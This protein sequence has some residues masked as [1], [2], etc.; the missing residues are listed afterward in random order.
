MWSL[1][2]TQEVDF[3]IGSSKDFLVVL[4]SLRVLA[5]K[6]GW[7]R[8]NTQS[9]FKRQS[10]TPTYPDVVVWEFTGGQRIHEPWDC[11][12]ASFLISGKRVSVFFFFF[13]SCLWTLKLQTRIVEHS[14]SL[15]SWRL[16]TLRL[17]WFCL[18]E[19]RQT[20]EHRFTCGLK[21]AEIITQWGRYSFLW[22]VETTGCVHPKT[23]FVWTR[24]SFKK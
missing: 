20:E 17:G 9:K 8:K 21:Q 24:V 23:C 19:H 14:W 10:S 5:H 15:L 22:L 12:A 18:A 7:F 13:F 3:P 2:F 11:F 1:V 4:V 16:F 6:T